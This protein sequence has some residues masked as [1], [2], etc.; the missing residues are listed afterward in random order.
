MKETSKERTHK[1][2]L[3]IIRIFAIL[4]VIFNHTNAR[5]YI[6]F[7]TV[8][9]KSAIYWISMIFSILCKVNV[10]LFFMISGVTLLGREETIQEVWNKRIV[11][12]LIVLMLFSLLQYMIGIKFDISQCKLVDFL[13]CIYSSNIIVPYWYLYC[14]LGFLVLLPFLRKLAKSMS[15]KD[16]L[17]LITLS[18]VFQ[19][20]IPCLQYRLFA[21]T[22][23]LNSSFNISSILSTIVLYPLA[24]YYIS[25]LSFSNDS[26]LKM[27]G[28]TLLSFIIVCYMITYQISI[29]D[30]FQEASMREFGSCFKIIQ[31]STIFIT[32][33]TLFEKLELTEACKKILMALGRCT[34]GIYLIEQ[35]LREHY[36]FIY[37]HLC[38]FMSPFIAINLYVLFIFSISFLIVWIAKK[39]PLIS[40]LI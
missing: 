24:G 28:I 18:V 3:D 26:L 35:P 33:K 29:I 10:P 1:T 20:I 14:Y 19:G 5:G 12:F 9:P 27:W 17:Y 6:Y 13:K 11:R 16:F 38:D 7:T 2:Y 40:R 32:C 39:I 22:V 36:Y 15:Q 4:T 37:N 25:K 21:G 8:E 34:F 23:V 30:E 31:V